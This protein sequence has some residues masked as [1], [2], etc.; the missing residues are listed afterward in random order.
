MPQSFPPGPNKYNG[1]LRYLL[2]NEKDV[3]KVSYS[4][5]DTNHPNSIFPFAP[6]NKSQGTYFQTWSSTEQEFYSIG[7]KKRVF[8][9]HFSI[10]AKTYDIPWYPNNWTLYGCFEGKCSVIGKEPYNNSLTVAFIK[11]FPVIPGFYDNITF[12]AYSSVKPFWTINY[13]DVFGYICNNLFDCNGDLLIKR[14]T[15]RSKHHVS[16][17][18]TFIIMMMS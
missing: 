9:T 4:T 15:L 3:L 16:N 5:L 12:Y 13:F 10:E 11:R 14:C 8:I 18:F 2:Y 6:L 7:I 1:I 17:F